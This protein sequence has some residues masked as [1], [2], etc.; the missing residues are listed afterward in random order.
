MTMLTRFVRIMLQISFTDYSILNFLKIS[1]QN[2]PQ[3]SDQN[4]PQNIS[5]IYS[6]CSTYAAPTIIIPYQFSHSYNLFS[7]F[8]LLLDSYHYN[9]N[10]L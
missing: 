3:I 5:I 10:K 6:L 4:F 2:F 1:Y 7:F 9:D 8:L